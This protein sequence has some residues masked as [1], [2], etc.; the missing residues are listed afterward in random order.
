MGSPPTQTGRPRLREAP[1]PPVSVSDVGVQEVPEAPEAEEP[2]PAEAMPSR[3]AR[4]VAALAVA[5][6]VT[7]LLTLAAVAHV[8]RA[9]GAEGFGVLGYGLALFGYFSL[10]ARPG[11][12]T[13]AVREIARAPDRVGP[14]ARDVTSLQV[15]LAALAAALYVAVVFALGRPPAERAALLLVGLPLLAQPFAL[16]W[17]Y[18]GVERM[19]VL[20]VRNVAAAVLQLALVLALVRG[21]GDL[22]WAAAAQGVALAAVSAALYLAYRRD[23]G[24]LRLRVDVAAWGR[25]L[26]PA[27]PIATSVFMV[28]IYYN[29]D[30]LMLGEIRGDEAVGLYEAAYRWVLV[31]L[32]PGTILVQAF[33]PTLSA[34]LGDRPA[35]EERARAYARANVGV[36][37]PIALGGGLLAAPLI[38]FLAG[39]AFGA[40]APVLRLLMVNVGVVYVN[41]AL[42]Q[43]LLAWNLQTPYMWA[44]GGGAAANVALNVVLI[45]TYGA[46]GA[47]WAT[48]GAEVVVLV[49]LSALYWRTVRTLPVSATALALCAAALGV[50]VP[51]GAATALGWPWL[52]GAA[53]AAPA[54]AAAAWA[55]GVV[56]PSD[57]R[58]LLRR[59]A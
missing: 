31:A 40:A 6:G 49:A 47:A 53:L 8:T 39:D 58:V 11:L 42:S 4:N 14:L 34:A 12:D 26:R 1:R 44:V 56:R 2:L 48:V 3:V 9:L 22:V 51:I 41:L 36:G 13:L 15:A 7:M 30:K 5:R 54:Y 27:L 32:V 23:F 50:G 17:V 52:A 46:W 35:M 57:L 20:A 59:R 38:A 10:L 25:L 19:G 45:P 55:L 24:P 43:P 28:L 33:F 18:Q 16:D 29:L 37:F 21:P